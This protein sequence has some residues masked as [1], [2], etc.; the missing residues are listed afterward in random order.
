MKQLRCEEAREL[1]VPHVGQE[2]SFEADE[3]LEA[4][5][6]GCS[7]CAALVAEERAFQA[8]LQNAAVEPSAEL[9][10]HCRRGLAETLRTPERSGGGAGWFWG[11]VD[12]WRRYAMPVAVMAGLAL[13]FAVGRAFEERQ[14]MAKLNT[15]SSVVGVEGMGNGMVQLVVQEPRQRVIR[16]GL[17]D[18]QIE[19]ALLAAALGAPDAGMRLESVDLLRNRCNNDD[20]RRTMLK[21]L[22]KDENAVV[23][24]R[25][26]EALR[27]YAAEREV[28]QVLARVLLS[29]T[30]ANVRLQAIDL[31]AD[32]TP[33]EYVGTLQEVMRRD[34]NVDV[35][36]RCL[37][38]LSDLRASPG[39]F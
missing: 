24:M 2:L 10:A 23:R 32:R 39:V 19:R 30:N 37:R 14:T 36:T 33:A 22:E 17:H 38:V 34:E 3:E 27:P 7:A 4:H 16:G 35:R 8:L 15:V 9:L 21:T 25:A 11:M 13:A 18:E 6:A 28:R 5:L 20:V 31:L 1:I 12:G 29:D 26:M